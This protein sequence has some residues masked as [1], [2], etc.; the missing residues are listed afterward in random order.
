[1]PSRRLPAASRRPFVAALALL[2]L[3]CVPAVQAGPRERAVT[4]ALVWL[5][6]SDR[7]PRGRLDAADRRAIARAERRLGLY[8]DGFLEPRERRV[9]LREADRRRAREGYRLL[10]DPAT[11]ARLGVPTAWTAPARAARGGTQWAS[12]DG[13]IALRSFV[14]RVPLVEM[15]RRRRALR[16]TRITYDAKGRDRA[17]RHWVVLSGYRHGRPFYT[18][19]VQG[20]G[21]VRGFRVVFD[22]ALRHRLERV[23]VAMS[24][25]YDPFAS[26]ALARL[27][28]TSRLDE[29]EPFDEATDFAETVREEGRDLVLPERPPLPRFRP[30]R[31]ASLDERIERRDLPR[32][33][34][35][36]FDDSPIPPLEP[37]PRE[38]EEGASLDPAARDDEELSVERPDDDRTESAVPRTI[39]GMLTD[40][41]QS[42]PTLRAPD[43]TLY[44]LVGEVPS[45]RPGTLVTITAVEVGGNRCS[46]GRPVAVSSFRVRLER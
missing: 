28:E 33:G 36:E 9:L 40:E 31:V 17:G 45:V 6:V 30:E 32:V 10:R 4:E 11:G 20:R 8:A 39:T 1:M 16:G 38:P 41:G 13:A 12:P 35:S 44:A 15:E 25:D 19:M 43:G 22:E 24:A 37:A 46:A 29:T 21:E 2:V 5:G 34:A 23:V 18:R 27:P 42:C 14:S 7:V 26:D 3:L